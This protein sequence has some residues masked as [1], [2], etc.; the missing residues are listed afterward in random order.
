MLVCLTLASCGGDKK[1]DPVAQSVA[2]IDAALRRATEFVLSHQDESGAFRSRTYSAFKDGFSLTPLILTSLR[3]APRSPELEGAYAR[4]VDFLATLV[5]RE[6]PDTE[7]GTEP[8][9]GPDTGPGAG[10]ELAHPSYP[11]YAIAGAVLVL[12]VPG[13]VRHRRAR[14]LLLDALRARQLTEQHGW[15]PDDLSYGGWGYFGGIP[16][17]PDDSSGRPGA[18]PDPMLTANLSA[19]LFAVGALSLAGVSA[20]DPVLSKALAFVKRCQNFA[21]SQ[22]TSLD[23]TALDGG[24]FFSPAVPDGN[25]AG[26]D[27]EPSSGYRSYGSMTADGLRALIRLGV[28]VDHPRVRAAATWLHERYTPARNPGDFPPERAV[29]QESAYFYYTWSSA[30]ALRALG[31]RRFAAVGGEIDWPR[32]LAAELLSRQR[33]DGSWAN[34][35]SEM[36]ED[37]P[38]LATAFAMA[39]LAN[40]QAVLRGVYRSHSHEARD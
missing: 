5:T 29:R 34:P 15:Q 18:G 40:A 38:L 11:T 25:K 6:E 20:N 1:P 17:K 31:T 21:E 23:A 30:H 10:P 4:G 9:A 2:Q 33:P 19:T 24:F 8:D 16:R 35:Y 22:N 13:N 32:A 14:D 27:G 37:D 36:R 26:P 7:L 12:N 39:G 3:F 28:P